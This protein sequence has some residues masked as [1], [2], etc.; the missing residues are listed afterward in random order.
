MAE[1]NK[2][3]TIKTIKRFLNSQLMPTSI[4]SFLDENPNRFLEELKGER[5]RD[6]EGKN[7]IFGDKKKKNQRYFF[8]RLGNNI[9]YYF[10]SHKIVS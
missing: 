2:K 8:F 5:K 7:K 6:E 3:F 4:Y 10:E 9:F 1:E